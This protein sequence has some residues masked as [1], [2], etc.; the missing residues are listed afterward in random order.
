MRNQ[1]KQRKESEMTMKTLEQP[2]TRQVRSEVPEPIY[3]ARGRLT[4]KLMEFERAIADLEDYKARAER[5]R[6]DGDRAMEDAESTESQAAAEISRCQNEQN[7]YR[8]RQAQREK[9]ITTL[10]GELAAAINA[11]AGELRG[12]VNLEVQ[13]RREIIGARVLEAIEAVDS[14]YRAPAVAEIL[15]F[16]GP[17]QRVL[18]LNPSFQIATVGNNEALVQTAKDVLSKFGVAVAAAGETI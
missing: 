2:V 17:I 10:S 6:I 3:P 12:R 7:V 1:N 9:A 8:A 14:P 13:R 15:Q 16:S 18:R 4:G 5:A 11:T